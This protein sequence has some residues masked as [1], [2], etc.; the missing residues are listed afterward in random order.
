M[1]DKSR[2]QMTLRHA[3]LSPSHK[4]HAVGV[5]SSQMDTIWTPEAKS[6]NDEKTV[7]V[8]TLSDK[9]A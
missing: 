7:E 4:T 3:H 6:K 1:H 2:D 8:V 5:L 9:I